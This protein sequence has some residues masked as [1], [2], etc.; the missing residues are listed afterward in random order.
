[1]GNS[2]GSESHARH[3]G[4]QRFSMSSKPSIRILESEANKRGDLFGRLMSDLFLALGYGEIRLNI[5]KPGREIDV[6]GTHRTE[7]R[8]VI[9][10][11][12]STRRKAGGDD[13]NK[14]VG[15]LDAERRKNGAREKQAHA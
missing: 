4:T 6:E 8:R 13:V 12:K 14:F 5:P 2:E 1:M 7:P 11:C 10:E 15:I 3:K 9:A